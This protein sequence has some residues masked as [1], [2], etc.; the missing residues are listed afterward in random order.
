MARKTADVTK[1]VSATNEE[2]LTHSTLL[3]GSAY[4]LRRPRLAVERERRLD[5]NHTMHRIKMKMTTLHSINQNHVPGEAECNHLQQASEGSNDVGDVDNKST[6]QNEMDL[7]CCSCWFRTLD[8]LRRKVTSC[9]RKFF[10]AQT[11]PP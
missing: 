9:Y 11:A 5:N 10:G 2:Y 3:I 6:L 8:H 7:V 1:L 4:A